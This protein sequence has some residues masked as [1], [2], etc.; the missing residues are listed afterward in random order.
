MERSLVGSLIGGLLGL[1]SLG[2]LGALGFVF[3]G[4]PAPAHGKPGGEWRLL[5]AVTYENLSVFP[6]VSSS[7]Y[8]TS[9][10]LTLDEGLASGEVQV[11]ERGSGGM[12]RNR[13]DRDGM[14]R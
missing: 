11:R 3:S 14:H 10:F 5:N 9:G 4:A 7:S 13:D 2:T 6:V 12:V 8:D 1:G